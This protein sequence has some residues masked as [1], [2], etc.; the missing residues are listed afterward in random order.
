MGVPAKYADQMFSI[1]KDQVRWISPEDFE[2]DFTGFIPELK[3]WV[4]ARCD[5]LTNVEKKI[6]ESLKHTTSAGQ[7]VAEKIMIEAIMK[8]LNAQFECEL[9]IQSELTL[10]AYKDA[11]VDRLR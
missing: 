5:K 4:D 11:L 3:D 6:W 9:D 1:P 10:R 7:S 2:A 8:K